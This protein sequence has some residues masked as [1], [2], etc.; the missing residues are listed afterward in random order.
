MLCRTTA[1]VVQD[2]I[3]PSLSET[4]WTLKVAD[5]SG[6]RVILALQAPIYNGEKEYQ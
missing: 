1:G 4:R 3:L 2:C 6:I 5:E